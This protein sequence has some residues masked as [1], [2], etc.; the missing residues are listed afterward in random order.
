MRARRRLAL[1]SL[2]AAA[3]VAMAA[4]CAVE[5]QNIKP[6]QALAREALPEGERYIGWRVFQ[7][8]CASCHGAAATGSAAAPDLLPRLREMGS[9]QFVGLVLRRYD[10]ILAAAESNPQA[11]GQS[12]MVEKVLLGREA[13]L[14]MPAWQGDPTVTAH[15]IDL[16]AYLAARA[17]GTQG[18]GRPAP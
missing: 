7:Q 2:S 11:A 8:K 18:P 14:V 4:G 12:A 17:D 13:A 10:W 5:L 6:A 9:H 3:L 1:A 15:I 16:Y